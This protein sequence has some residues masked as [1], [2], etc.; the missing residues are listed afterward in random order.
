MDRTTDQGVL[1]RREAD[2]RALFANGL[3][4]D[5]AAYARFLTDLAALLRGYLRNR[6]R[7]RPEDV[8]DL[9]QE[10]LLAVHNARHTYLPGQPLTAWVHAIARYKLADHLRAHSRHDALNDPLDDTHDLLAA[11]DLEPAQARRDL[12]VLLDEL[13][14]KQRLPIVHVK[15][16][17]LSVSEAAR[18]T[19]LSESAVKVGVHR[20][21]KALAAK[22]RGTR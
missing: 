19:G 7:G 16:E 11:P 10:V 12:N 15:L 4:G 3:A 14:D 17:G 18:M 9:T 5:R 21:L 13:P 1:R 2:L 22:I 20:G 6:L 8:E